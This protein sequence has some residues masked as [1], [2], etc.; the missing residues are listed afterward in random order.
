M[1]YKKG[2]CDLEC[3]RNKMQ[4]HMIKNNERKERKIS[5]VHKIKYICMKVIWFSSVSLNAMEGNVSV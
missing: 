2:D 3:E 5:M 4:K 1:A